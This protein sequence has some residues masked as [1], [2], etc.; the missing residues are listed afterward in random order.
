MERGRVHEIKASRDSTG[1]QGATV[2]LNITTKCSFVKFFE[3]FEKKNRKY[4]LEIIRFEARELLIVSLGNE[5]P[6]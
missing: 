2:R 5:V 6:K 3:T 1:G 4:C